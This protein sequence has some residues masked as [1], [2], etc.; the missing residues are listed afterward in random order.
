MDAYSKLKRVEDVENI[1]DKIS[2]LGLAN[3]G[4]VH[5]MMSLNYMELQDFDKA[6]SMNE[7]AAEIAPNDYQVYLT[8][9]INLNKISKYEA[10]IKKFKK[11]SM[12]KNNNPYIYFYWGQSLFSLKKFKDSIHMFKRASIFDRKL[13]SSSNYWIHRAEQELLAACDEKTIDKNT[14]FHIP[15][16]HCVMA[17]PRE[18]TK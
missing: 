9:G 2:E 18:S 15:T 4:I 6:L 8:W 10:A 11:A 12:L 7:S 5:L 17:L 13:N 1:F 14:G 16:A 3:S